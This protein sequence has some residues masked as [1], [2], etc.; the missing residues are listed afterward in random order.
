MLK[1]AVTGG[2]ACGKSLAGAMLRDLGMSVCEADDIARELMQPGTDVYTRVISAFGRE[3][4]TDDGKIDR[5]KLAEAIFSSSRD[6][7]RLNRIVHPAVIDAIGSWLQEVEKSCGQPEGAVAIVP[8]L[9]EA[10]AGC[11]WDAVICVATDR[12]TQIRRLLERGLGRQ[13]AARRIDAQMNVEEKAVRSDYVIR[14]EGGRE[15]LREQTERILKSIRRQK[16][17]SK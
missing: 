5:E 17:G 3:V 14:N 11:G 12:N 15:V 8:L 7:I 10:Q 13:D 6:R 2:I 9:Y 4:T 1:I 16:H